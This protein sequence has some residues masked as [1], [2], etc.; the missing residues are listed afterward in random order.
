MRALMLCLLLLAALPAAAE[1]YRYTDEKGVIH[2]TDK[3][4]SKD[5]KPAKL[6]PLQSIPGGM[7]AS[8]PASAVAS[9]PAATATATRFSVNIT[10]PT[11][12][13]TLRDPSSPVSIAVSVMPGLVGGY[14]LIYYVDGEPRNSSPVGDTSM[15]VSGLERGEHLLA[16]A[17]VD[18][19]G[20]EVA[21]SPAVV[22]HLKQ[23][24]LPA[25]VSETAK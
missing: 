9:A 23:P 12:D 1:V 19:A 13:E 17:I 6:P 11:P 14:G 16:V 4:P 7:P 15:S 20:R 24:S 21:R 8:P 5:A 25:P 3:P 22:V 10:S 2:Y 18:N